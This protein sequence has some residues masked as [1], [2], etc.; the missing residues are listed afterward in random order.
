MNGSEPSLWTGTK[1]FSIMKCTGVA[2][3]NK[4]DKGRR[5][6]TVH[7]FCLAG[8]PAGLRFT[9]DLSENYL[10]YMLGKKLGMSFKKY[11]CEAGDI[12]GCIFK[13][14]VE[15]GTDKTTIG[16]IDATQKMKDMNKKLI[17]SRL[18]MLKC[19]T[20]NIACTS[21]KKTRKQCLL[22]VWKG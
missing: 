14:T 20:P 19:K 10:V 3:C 12:A 13:C 11:N 18:S 6:L 22:A 9:V 16:D 5:Y 8:D 15:Q 21:C 4:V 7:L 2:P 17:G 1:A